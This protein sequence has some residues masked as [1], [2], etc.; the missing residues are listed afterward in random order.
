MRRSSSSDGDSRPR[1]IAR[2]ALASPRAMNGSTGHSTNSEVSVTVKVTMPHG[3]R[4]T[5]YSAVRQPTGS[6]SAI[7]S[8]GRNPPAPCSGNRLGSSTRTPSSA[9]ARARSP[10]PSSRVPIRPAA[11]SGQPRPP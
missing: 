9:L 11:R 5:S 4:I 10:L 8:R 6:F 7:H 1:T 3:R 2:S